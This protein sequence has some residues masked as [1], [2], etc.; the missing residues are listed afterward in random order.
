MRVL[1]TAIGCP[2]GPSII[3]C[4]RGSIETIIGTDMSCEVASKHFVDRFYVVP[5]GQNPDYV[6]EMLAIAEREKIEVI[7]PLATFELEPLA[8][9]KELF[10]AL[11]CEICVSDP[12]SLEVAIDKGALYAFFEDSS[13]IPEFVV[14]YT[15]NDVIDFARGRSKFCIKPR[16]GHGGRGFHIIDPNADLFDIFT[17]QKLS[18][19]TNMEVLEGV[20]NSRK[21]FG[22]FLASEYFPGP[23]YN[24]DLLLDPRAHKIILGLVRENSVVRQGLTIVGRLVEDGALLAL[25]KDIAEEL[26]LSYTVNVEFK[27]KDGVPKLLEINPRVPATAYLAYKAG[28]NMPLLSVL[29]A[30]GQGFQLPELKRRRGLEVYSFERYLVVESGA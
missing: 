15:W 2:G 25:A 9:N 22:G 11:G 28:F 5:P 7:L 14:P 21:E 10:S 1:L 29:L 24:V 13:F 27:F 8:R 18:P 23:E 16:V 19:L 17:N 6:Q 3:E 12:R 26:E 4:L 30:S 20:L